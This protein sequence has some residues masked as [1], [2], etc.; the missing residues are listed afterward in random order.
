MRSIPGALPP[1]SNFR[2]PPQCPENSTLMARGSRS[3]HLPPRYRRE[4]H[5]LVVPNHLRRTKHARQILR[6]LPD[7]SKQWV[8]HNVCATP[9]LP[10]SQK[11]NIVS[12]P[13]HNQ[14]LLLCPFVSPCLSQQVWLRGIAMDHV[15]GCECRAPARCLHVN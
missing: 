15:R 5:R 10:L 14:G 11:P 9:R 3:Y 6:S 8:H 4:E 12:T 2:S 1:R 13:Q 7:I